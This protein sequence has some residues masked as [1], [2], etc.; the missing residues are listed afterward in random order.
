NGQAVADA[1]VVVGSTMFDQ[2]RSATSDPNGHYS[3]GDLPVGPLTFSAT[4]A[5]GNVAFAAA[6]IRTAG[7]L[8]LQDISIYR[9]PFPGTATVRGVVMRS[10]TNTI[11]VGAHVGVYTQGY[12]LVDG[13][14][15]S[16]G[17]FEFAK[18]PSGFVT[19]LASEWT[20]SRESI[21]IDFD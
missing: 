2:F 18:V 3:V 9:R 4:D 21:A 16:S 6:E 13:F 11:V 10:D 1:K 17:R 5:A 19:V 15:D 20:I 14:T 8:L 7:Q 12:G